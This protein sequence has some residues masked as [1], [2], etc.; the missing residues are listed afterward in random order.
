MAAGSGRDN[1]ALR[2]GAVGRMVPV[3][4]FD[5]LLDAWCDVQIPLTV[6]GDGPLLDTLRDRARELVID[7][8]V[9]FPGWVDADAMMSEVDIIVMSSLREGFSYVVLEALQAECMVVATRTGVAPDLVPEPF[10]VEPGNASELA[11]VVNAIL[12]DP[13]SARLA[14]EPAWSTA[15]ALTLGRMVDEIESVYGR[16][17]EAHT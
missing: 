16:A 11:G 12:D 8:R 7:D 5:V 2:A 4:G 14:F 13:Q 3:K 15:K 17:I 9:A 1:T 10:L 6:G